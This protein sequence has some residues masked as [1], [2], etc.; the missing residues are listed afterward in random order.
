MM[1]SG[2]SRLPVA[3]IT[4]FLGSGKTTLL[5]RLLQ[6]PDMSATAVVI[7][8]F[9][10]VPLDQLF[11][12]ETDGEVVVMAN[13]CLCCSVQDDI[14]GVIGRLFAR[15][16]QGTLPAFE[17][18]LIETSGLAD[19]APIMQMLLNQPLVMDNFRLDSVL[20]M[21]DAVNGARQIAE[22][23]EAFKQVVL[24]D[25]LVL[26]KTDL[27]SEET[28]QH[29]KRELARLN[30]GATLYVATQGE[31]PPS[32][33]FGA[34]RID[35]EADAK[36]WVAL[37]A[38]TPQGHHTAHTHTQAV[39]CCTLAYPSAIAWRELNRWLTALRIK[40]GEKLLRVKGIVELEGEDAPVALHGVH[41]VF[42]PP[43]KLTH[44]RDK[45]MH[46]ARLVVIVRDIDIDEIRASWQQFVAERSG[47]V[48]SQQ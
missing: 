39:A 13:G 34:S 6:H 46:G 25:T 43:L 4:G 3:L 19:P 18:M 14:E 16:D 22:N 31:L 9:G 7:N 42:H 27:A 5:N 35:S 45:G 38:A 21:V 1:A 23:E 48:A 33:L 28:T 17:R 15:R 10:D 32:V 29:I 40:H 20:T 26:T 12:E 47:A 11:V 24:A 8:E 36:R 41:H 2:D 30:P 37:E 44:L